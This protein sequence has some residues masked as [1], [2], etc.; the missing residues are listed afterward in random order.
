MSAIQYGH[1]QNDSDNK[2]SVSAKSSTSIINE[3]TF[4]FW[5]GHWE[6]TWIDA[7]GNSSKGY[8]NIVKILD[9]KVLQENFVDKVSKYKGMSLSV[10]NPK[11]KVW[12]QAWTDNFGGY[13]NFIGDIV[14]GN[15]VFKTDITEK[16]GKKI[17][18]RMVFKNRK[19]D[20][21]IWIWEGTQDGGKTWYLIWKINY[22]R[23]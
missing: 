14:D 2:I 5:V 15:P 4:D 13:Y 17:Q 11:T 6:L 16:D 7:K 21:F 8:N 10:F 20:T 19:K 9:D 22:K 18:Q 23:I 12:H 3:K 1:S